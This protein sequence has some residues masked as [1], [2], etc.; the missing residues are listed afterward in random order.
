IEF[1]GAKGYLV[2]EE[3]QGFYYMIEALNLSRVSNAVSSLGIM[4]RAYLEARNYAMNRE[5]FGNKLTHYP[6]VQET[7][8]KLAAKQEIELNAVFEVVALMDRVMGVDT[9]VK[10]SDKERILFRLYVAIMKV[11]TAEQAIRFSQDR[12]S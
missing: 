11:E 10:A 8:S 5:A 1:T 9:K 12:K 2:G 6:M 7:L 4:R 3:N